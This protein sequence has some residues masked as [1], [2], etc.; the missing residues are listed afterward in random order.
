M[1]FND[2]ADELRN[3][4]SFDWDKNPTHNCDTREEFIARKLPELLAA[5]SVGR[6]PMALLASADDESAIVSLCERVDGVIEAA[7]VVQQAL[8]AYDNA[9]MG[10]EAVTNGQRLSIQN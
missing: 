7:R 8:A 4:W 3:W 1:D 5:Y 9:T 10:R 6:R 2:L